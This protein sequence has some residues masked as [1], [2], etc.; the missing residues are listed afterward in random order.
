M[1]WEV[2]QWA[3]FSI[4]LLV[5]IHYIFQNV[6]DKYDLLGINIFKCGSTAV[7]TMIAN[8]IMFTSIFLV[9]PERWLENITYL[10]NPAHIIKK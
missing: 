4:F 1:K 8:I 10:Y 6:S 2:L 5:I 3:A 7:C 9:I